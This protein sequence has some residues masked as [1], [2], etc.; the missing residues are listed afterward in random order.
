MKILVLTP[1]YPSLDKD[2]GGT[3][4]IHY[5]VKEW[6]KKGHEVY[7]IHNKA[8]YHDVFYKIPN[9]IIKKVE[10]KLGSPIINVKLSDLDY[11]YEGIPVSRIPIKKIIPHGDFSKREI[12]NQFDKIK[13]KLVEVNFKPD[14]VIGHWESPQIQLVS[15][16]KDFYN[17]K[18]AII[19]HLYYK[20]YILKNNKKNEYVD[21]LKNIDVIGFRSKFLRDKFLEN[22]W[23]PK[24]SFICYSGVPIDDKIDYYKNVK[25]QFKN[26]IYVGLL[27]QRKY[28]DVLLDALIEY[29]KS[30]KEKL[31]LNFIGEGNL[32]NKLNKK[33]SNSNLEKFIKMKGRLA[34]KDVFLEMQKADCL[35]MISKNEAFGLV[36]LEAMLNGCIVVASK[37]EGMDGII[38]NGIN[39]FLCNSGNKKELL[40]TFNLINNLSADQREVISKKAIETALRFTE[41][42]VSEN[43]L[44][45]IV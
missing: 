10:N 45:S 27:V 19:L 5:F 18:S 1:I 20:S 25:S 14:I 8:I 16:L 39:G 37:N 41:E 31:N 34:R 15:L 29:N 4:V 36:Y 32:K 40:E 3:K 24:K 17:I 12:N 26:I 43:Y 7:V 22:F 2:K 28:P 42:N 6:V 23:T 38:E 11:I 21:Y 13:N 44:K 9:F 33:I 30:N 35:V